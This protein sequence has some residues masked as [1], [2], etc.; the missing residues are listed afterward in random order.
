[1]TSKWEQMKKLIQSDEVKPWDLLSPANY[2]SDEI[3]GSRYTICKQC[4]KFNQGVK[5]CQ[6]CGCFMP[7]KTKLDGATC[8][9]GKW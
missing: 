7:A 1:M 8:P 6:E 4:P 2:I 9:I 5:T 3:A